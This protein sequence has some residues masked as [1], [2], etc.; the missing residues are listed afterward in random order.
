MKK[1]LITIFAILLCH[2]VF[3]DPDGYVPTPPSPPI[4][5]KPE[6]V[7][8][9]ISTY[10]P[11]AW[12]AAAAQEYQNKMDNNGGI[13]VQG[14]RSVCTAGHLDGN[15]CDNFR[16]MIM[17][18]YYSVC[19]DDKGKTG[20]QEHCIKDFF[21]YAAP[22]ALS[23]GQG[24]YVRMKE[25]LGLA[26]EY[27]LIKTGQ[28]DVVCDKPRS[29]KDTILCASFD[30][31][32]YY[33][34]KFNSIT[35]TK[36]DAIK[37]STL[38]AVC[39]MHDTKYQA[40]AAGA[41]TSIG[42][43][44]PGYS[45][46]DSCETSNK[47]I[48]DNI[49]KSLKRFSYKSS[50]GNSDVPPIGNHT[51]CVI[52]RVITDIS[53]MRTAFNIDN[54]IFKNVQ[55][56]ASEDIDRKIK[57]YVKQQL[58][59]QG[60]TFDAQ[61]FHCADSTNVT[62]NG[63]V[64][65]CYVNDKPID[66]LFKDLSEWSGVNRRGSAQAMDCIVSGGTYTGKRCTNLNQKQ[67]EMLR[68]ANIKSCPNC[69]QVRW[70]TK[71]KVCTLPSSAAAT[72]LQK[73]LKIVAIVGGTVVGVVVTIASGGTAGLSAGAY[74]ILGVE[75]TG[76]GI[77]LWSQSKID[78]LADKFFLRANNCNSADCATLLVHQYLTDLAS[79]NRD[80]TSDEADAVDKEMA[81]LVEL[82][83]TDS[84]WWINNLKN[85]DGTS[86]LE[87]A[88]NGDW[89]PA[90]V[91]RAIGIGMQFAGIA[92]SA[93]KWVLTKTG[94]LTKTLNRTTKIL[95]KNAK[96][97]QK[98]IVKFDELSD[99][100]KEW[101]KLWQE[102][103]PKNQTLEQFKA[104]A[105]G[106]LDEMRQMVR[107]WTPNSE[108]AEQ[109][110][111]IYQ[112]LAVYDDEL[113]E[114]EQLLRRYGIDK[115]PEDPAEIQRIYNQY[116]DIKTAHQSLV[117]Q[118]VRITMLKN[119]RDLLVGGNYS[120]YNPEFSRVAKSYEQRL[121]DLNAEFQR[122]YD[123]AWTKYHRSHPNKT[124]ED[125]EN[126]S[127]QYQAIVNRYNKQYTQIL[128]DFN[129]QIAE[130][131][132]LENLENIALERMQAFW[133]DPYFKYMMSQTD[134]AKQWANL[135]NEERIR[136]IQIVLNR[137][138]QEIGTPPVRIEIDNTIPYAGY[139]NPQTNTIGI[140]GKSLESLEDAMSAI[141]PHEAAHQI[142][143]LDPNRGGLGE[144][145]AH[146][147]N[148]WYATELDEG[149]RVSLTEQ[150]SYRIGEMVSGQPQFVGR[151]KNIDPTLG[152][153]V[154]SSAGAATVI[155]GI[156]SAIELDNTRELFRKY[157]N[158]KKE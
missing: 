104:M 18:Y 22:Q 41:A 13:T 56:L 139:Y 142:D 37:Q 133:S 146:Y 145:Y 129:W 70:D 155:G 126:N 65:T 48:C 96:I 102:Y 77:E 116:P 140:S 109:L 44:A 110:R 74:V 59:K 156:N 30:K 106:N 113:T 118:Q 121:A 4:Y 36:D 55:V 80:L 57:E 99:L 17:V 143:H 152:S 138:A 153:A 151:P 157:G 5:T 31:T 75:T 28:K 154:G 58:S 92:A 120:T 24:T 141:G 84:D 61:S 68:D 83:P 23:F 117:N 131:F 16:N 54:T 39:K 33:E 73:D 6:V 130:E 32:H 128:S 21:Y 60:I 38:S 85:D 90:Q 50:L 11:F 87:K 112:Q 158:N 95:E 124:I 63:D 119:Q 148:R 40:S 47:P 125:F 114:F 101:Y 88:D 97:A 20:K 62:S 1:I 10:V 91:W 26:K 46:P 76:A 53:D 66:F 132:P 8:H 49:N 34:F 78:R 150:S 137:Y 94:Y 69:N 105:N 72:N 86:F 9:A 3:A 136:E 51:T 52:E 15:Q 144:Q 98:Y 27:A 93:T 7:E 135:S 134:A 64:M 45:W 123:E 35:E 67:C 79:I 103:A 115:M 43:N 82:I 111:S 71:K 19:G 100:D 127:Y 25:A 14:L 147:A 89:T 29:K 12:Q 81:R 2:P 149:Y 108:T 122:Q 42:G 107:N